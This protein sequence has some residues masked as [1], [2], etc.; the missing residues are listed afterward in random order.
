MPQLIGT[1]EEELAAC[2]NA[3]LA[4]KHS[5]NAWCLHHNQL[6]EPLTESYENRI[7]CIL[8]NK[9]K[10]EHAVRFRN[11]RPMRVQP[12]K[13]WNEAQ[14]SLS[15]VYFNVTKT[16]SSWKECSHEW[17]KACTKMVEASTEFSK[18][19]FSEMFRLDWPDN[20]WNGADVFGGNSE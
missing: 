12:V 16:K 1:I 4:N 2:R 13:E 7:K 15:K 19:D 18:I 11:F 8:K 17:K 6:F 5:K 9:P 3:F 20:T 10:E 14:D